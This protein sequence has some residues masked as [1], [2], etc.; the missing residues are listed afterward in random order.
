MSWG[1]SDR[2]R[3]LLSELESERYA[4]ARAEDLLQ[5]EQEARYRE[6][7]EAR[8]ARR[9]MYAEQRES[10]RRSASTWPEALRKQIDLFGVEAHQDSADDAAGAWFVVQLQ[11]CRRALEL[12]NTEEAKIADQVAAL[13][14]RVAEL[15]DGV[16][17]AVAD[18]LDAEMPQSDHVART[19]RETPEDADKLSAWLHW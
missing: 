10:N 9:A 15:R 16:R 13:L 8:R 2:D 11:A 17:F 7:E 5:R 19:L 4:R 12:W 18:R 1:Q 3:N 14:A 6:A